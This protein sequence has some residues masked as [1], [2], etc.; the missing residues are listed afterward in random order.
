MDRKFHGNSNG[1][2]GI[3]DGSQRSQSGIGGCSDAK[4]GVLA[5]GRER[6]DVRCV[7]RNDFAASGGYKWVCP[8]P[9]LWEAVLVWRWNFRRRCL[10]AFALSH[11][12]FER[13]DVRVCGQTIVGFDVWRMAHLGFITHGAGM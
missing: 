4:S 1:R 3:Y 11:L 8:R 9:L 10:V 12:G 6:N 13:G 7:G 5:I 2:F